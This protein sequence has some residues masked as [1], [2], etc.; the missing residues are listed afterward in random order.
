MRKNHD[1][2]KHFESVEIRSKRSTMVPVL[3]TPD[4]ITTM[5]FLVENRSKCDVPTDN[6]YLFAHPGALSHYRGS[7]SLHKHAMQ[8]NGL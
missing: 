1:L 3:L 5:N 6:A 8:T 4:M 2:A 7:E